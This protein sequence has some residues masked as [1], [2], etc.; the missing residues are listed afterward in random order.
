LLGDPALKLALPEYQ[1]VS[2]HIDQSP[3]GPA[4]DTLRA[5]Q[6]VTVQGAVLDAN[7]QV[8]DNF[9]GILY[10]TVFDKKV[11]A[12]TLG[13]DRGSFPYDYTVQRSIIFRGR[14]SVRQGRFSFTFVVPKDIDFAFGPGK[15]SYYVAEE[16][17]RRDGAGYLNNVIIGGIN[18]N[19]ELDRE[20]PE[21][22]VYLNTP[23]FV[24]GAIT[25]PNPTLLVHLADES[26]INVVGNSIG[27]DLEGVLDDDTQN[28]ILLNDF[29]EAELDDYRRGTV[30]YPLSKLDDGLHS[31]RVKAWD[32]ANNSSEGYTEFIVASSPTVA[33]QRVLNYPNPFTDR[34]CFQFDHNLANQEIDVLI[35]IFT[36]S[37]RLVKT[38][39]HTMFT[40][41]AI[42][43]DDC[44]PWDGRDDYGDRLARGVYLYQVKVRANAPGSA[45]LSGE[46]KF[47]KLVL[48]K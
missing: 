38:I 34:T 13:Q 44:I 46:S 42:R 12:R 40:D 18:P 14:A 9:N 10:P 23:D 27:H 19:V 5:L 1:V 25:G 47:E 3:L 21:V 16:S 39:E 11:A 6:R 31:I 24:F 37:G 36:I 17:T 4:P 30:R 8:F 41:G 15:I 20:G 29:Y 45:A 43:R 48:L 7:G 32:V 2:T 22:D 26:G 28:A 35:Q 33:L